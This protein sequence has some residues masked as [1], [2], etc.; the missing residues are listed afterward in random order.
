[1]S[2]DANL[3]QPRFGLLVEKDIDVPMRDGARLKADL[4]R[5]DDGGTFPA[6]IN[7][8]LYQKDKLWTPPP[9]LDGAPN[10]YMNWETVNPEWWVPRG[11]AALRVDTRGL[12]KSPGY[13][14]PFSLQ[15]LLSRTTTPTT[16]P[17]PTPYIPGQAGNRIF[18]C[19]SYRPRQRFDAPEAAR[20]A[21]SSMRRRASA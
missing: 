5:P 18:C 1:M 21:K 14:A 13:T 10:P 4:F 3:S 2:K 6:L 16:I 7:I 9:D 20:P 15:E 17:A 12:G 19:R 11:Y 8:G